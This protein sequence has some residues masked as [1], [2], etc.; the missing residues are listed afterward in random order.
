MMTKAHKSIVHFFDSPGSVKLFLISKKKKK[1]N[2]K[3]SSSAK[4]KQTWKR[5]GGNKE[6]KKCTL[7]FIE[8]NEISKGQNPTKP[9]TKTK[10]RV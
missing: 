6:G 2:I 4:Y 5:Y 10:T 3:T 1:S 7:S 8:K 9:K